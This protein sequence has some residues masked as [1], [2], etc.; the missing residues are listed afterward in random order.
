ML[1][2]SDFTLQCVIANHQ[3]P[4][5]TDASRSD[6][7]THRFKNIKNRSTVYDAQI[8]YDYFTAFLSK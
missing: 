8:F 1:F 5:E 6:N 4:A 2:L 3:N 7:T